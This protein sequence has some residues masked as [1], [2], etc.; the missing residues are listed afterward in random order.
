[1]QCVCVYITVTVLKLSLLI[2]IASVATFE[3][4]FNWTPKNDVLRIVGELKD[5]LMF[6]LQ[7]RCNQSVAVK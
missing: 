4:C 3:F 2:F 1:M 7:A 5:M 6:I